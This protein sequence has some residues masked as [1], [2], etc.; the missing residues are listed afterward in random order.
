VNEPSTST[1][2]APSEEDVRKLRRS[3][4]RIK[5]NE[6]SRKS[7]MKSKSIVNK[8]EQDCTRLEARKQLLEELNKKLDNDIIKFSECLL[9]RG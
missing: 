5:N 1:S 4:F 9:A 7:R 3:T 2:V 8:N 6:S